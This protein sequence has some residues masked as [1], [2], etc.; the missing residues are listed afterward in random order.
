MFPVHC[1]GENCEEY[2]IIGMPGEPPYRAGLVADKGWR[3][4]NDPEDQAIVFVCPKCYEK[5]AIGTQIHDTTV[6][7][8]KPK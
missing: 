5:G 4:L 7:A 2:T 6:A 1:A 8:F 3:S